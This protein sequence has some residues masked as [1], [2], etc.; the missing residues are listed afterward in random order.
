MS[1][2]NNEKKRPNAKYKL[3]NE[4]PQVVEI[5]H[6]Y[7]REHRLEK[8]SQ[9]VRDLYTEQPRRRFGLLHTLTGS[10]PNAML[11]GTIVFLCVLML[12]LSFFGFTGDSR[13]LE[14]NIISIK[15]KKYEGTVII[16][17]KKTIRKDKIARS[18]KAYTG[19]VSIAVFPA[20]KSGAEQNQQPADVFFHKIFF[21]N[22]QEEHY[23]F[24]VPFGQNE[25]ALVFQTEKK[26]L[27]LTM[28]PLD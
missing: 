14:G 23:R 13:E 5:V 19:P 1:D 2:D 17:I 20:V 6:Y 10:R 21:S 9:A 4:N 8:A 11:F 15:G 24:S 3:S 7:N 12:I 22:E 27:S 26:T 25:L 18:I 16:E 28:K